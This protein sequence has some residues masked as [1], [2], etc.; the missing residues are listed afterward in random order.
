MRY[1]SSSPS[2]LSSTVGCLLSLLLLCPVAPCPLSRVHLHTQ[3]DYLREQLLKNLF[4]LILL[5]Q[6]WVRTVMNS[7]M[8]RPVSNESIRW[9]RKKHIYAFLFYF[10]RGKKALKGLSLY[11]WIPPIDALWGAGLEFFVFQL[12]IRAIMYNLS[13]FLCIF[14]SVIAGK[15]RRQTRQIIPNPLLQLIQHSTQQTKTE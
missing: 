1:L 8:F 4:S 15:P 2:S 9:G 14:G 7:F 11:Y 6:H 10:V 13:F 5:R 3:G 12:P